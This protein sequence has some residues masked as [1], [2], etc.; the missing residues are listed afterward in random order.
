MRVPAAFCGIVG[1]KPTPQRVSGKGVVGFE[2]NQLVIADAVGFLGRNVS[3]VA[4]VTKIIVSDGVNL[5]LNN[6]ILI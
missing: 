1:L 3:D 2:A 6:H 5:I 4:I